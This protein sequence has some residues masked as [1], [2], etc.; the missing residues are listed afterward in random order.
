MLCTSVGSE[1]SWPKVY[2]ATTIL[3]SGN[4]ASGGM[5]GLL[6]SMTGAPPMIGGATESSSAL[7]PRI[8]ESR[9]LGLEVLNS[10]FKYRKNGTETEG[11]LFEY[12]GAKTQDEALLGLK[13]LR[14]VDVDKEMGIITV[15][16]SSR[17]RSSPRNRESLCQ[18]S[19]R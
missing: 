11:T 6:A 9:V 8:L 15:S 18:V 4:Q 13:V 3:P 10:K 5:L 17:T 14:A 7:F 1:I 2:M 19:R 12:I 16:A